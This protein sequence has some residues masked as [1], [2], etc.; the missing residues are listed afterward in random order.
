MKVLT[1]HPFLKHTLVY[2][3]KVVAESFTLYITKDNPSV[4]LQ[5]APVPF[6]PPIIFLSHR[7]VWYWIS[8]LNKFC[9]FKNIFG[10]TALARDYIM[11]LAVKKWTE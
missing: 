11:C 5:N 4:L 1:P 9:C 7:V 10:E 6:F 3:M 8:V 2:E